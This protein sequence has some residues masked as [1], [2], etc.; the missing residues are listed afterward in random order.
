MSAAKRRWH[1][2]SVCLQNHPLCRA[3]PFVGLSYSAV[4]WAIVL[5]KFRNSEAHVSAVQVAFF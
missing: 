3:E 4:V 1:V 2:R 5:S